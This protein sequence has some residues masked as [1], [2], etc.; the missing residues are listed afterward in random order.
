MLS[1]I[2]TRNFLTTFA[3]VAMLASGTAAQALGSF[4]GQYPT[5]LS[6]SKSLAGSSELFH[7]E[8]GVE[9]M[10]ASVAAGASSAESAS[11]PVPGPVSMRPGEDKLEVALNGGRGPS[12]TMAGSAGAVKA[13]GARTYGLS[14]V[15]REEPS[16]V[17]SIR[18]AG[19]I[20]VL[21]AAMAVGG[22]ASTASSEKRR[23]NYR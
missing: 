18:R 2:G 14:Q 5:S 6:L 17:L 22:L 15:V 7:I 23:G 16:S 4:D 12:G 11:V 9:Y 1:R 3:L 10:P 8:G 20:I 19:M 21:L 13:D